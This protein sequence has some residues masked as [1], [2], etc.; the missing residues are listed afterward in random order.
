MVMTNYRSILAVILAV[1]TTFLVSCGSPTAKV[2]STYTAQQIE[3][4]QNV[5]AT[6]AAVRST[7]PVL[8]GKIQ[9]R[10]WTDV[11]TYIHGP[12]GEL[13]Q[14]MSSLARQL[15]P[16]EQKA[17]IAASKDL[18]NRLQSLDLAA[19]KGNYEA[20]ITSYRAAVRDF[21]EFLRLVPQGSTQAVSS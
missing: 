17:A 15:L 2:P 18:F 3:Q 4:I 20:A 10:N 19:E 6:V 14:K 1:V 5:A 16:Q 12:F 13:R 8:E 9:D 7:M 11:R 21:D